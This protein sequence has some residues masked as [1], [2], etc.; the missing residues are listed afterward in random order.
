MT[1][2]KLKEIKDQA[3]IYAYK[4]IPKGCYDFELF[5]QIIEITV[6]TYIDAYTECGKEEAKL[7]KTIT[8]T[9]IKKYIEKTEDLEEENWGYI[10]GQ[11]RMY[12]D[13]QK[14][15]ERL[16]KEL[17]ANFT[18]Q[19]GLLDKEDDELFSLKAIKSVIKYVTGVKG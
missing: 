12:T 9:A 4:H 1:V 17:I 8:Q 15:R 3:S 18:E 14:E 11:T 19:L 10:E 5:R 16:C 6:K 13:L 2:K 7:N